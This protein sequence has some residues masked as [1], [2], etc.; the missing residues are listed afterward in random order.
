MELV[1]LPSRDKKT[2][3][4]K[5]SNFQ[6]KKKIFFFYIKNLILKFEILATVSTSTK[7]YIVTNIL[8]SEKIQKLV[9]DSEE[10]PR[11][12]LLYIILSLI[13]MLNKVLSE[14]THFLFFSHFLF[15]F[16]LPT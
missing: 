1:E 16:F 4:L 8:P 3:A 14:G 15:F 5:K 12:G 9:I 13:L 11:M 7:Q 10:Y 6:T 2:T